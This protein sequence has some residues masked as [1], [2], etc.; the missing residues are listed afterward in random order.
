MLITNLE[1]CIHCHRGLV[2]AAIPL[3]YIQTIPL[4]A[5]LATR[6]SLTIHEVIDIS[7]RG[8]KK[9]AIAA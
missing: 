9:V 6:K 3:V 4:V 8:D 5:F 7:V 1:G 2:L